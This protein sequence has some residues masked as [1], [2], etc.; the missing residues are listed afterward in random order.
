MLLS[1]YCFQ[2]TAQRHC[3]WPACKSLQNIVVHIF[4]FYKLHLEYQSCVLC[5]TEAVSHTSTW[6]GL[7]CMLNYLIPP[8]RDLVIK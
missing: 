8:L 6:S 4:P 2:K 3:A 1:M 7:D 5:Y